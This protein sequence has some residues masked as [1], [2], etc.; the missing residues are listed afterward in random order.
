MV[1]TEATRRSAVGPV[2]AIRD[3][4]MRYPGGA[5]GPVHALRGLSLEVYKGDFLAVRGPSGSG[6]TTLLR[7]IAGLETPTRGC[8]Q[9]AGVDLATLS[10]AQRTLMRRRAVGFVH[11]S[12]NLLPDLTAAE[13]VALPLRLDGAAQGEVQSRVDGGLE[14]LGIGP[15]ADRFPDAMSGGEQVRVAI[16]RALVIEPAILLADEPTGNLDRESGRAV[17]RLFEAL[18]RDSGVTILLVTHDDE[19]AAGAARVVDIVDGVV[20]ESAARRL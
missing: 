14:R 11:Q 3:L 18:H 12:L 19:V 6:K 7:T 5:S 15:L 13:N 9:V 10:D 2:I 20:R 8:V 1:Q 17:V 16:A 4:W